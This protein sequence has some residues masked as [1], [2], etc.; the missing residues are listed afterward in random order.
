MV[1]NR[2]K[3][4]RLHYGMDYIYPITPGYVNGDIDIYIN[5]LFL[6]PYCACVIP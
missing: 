1:Q 2:L 3:I 6:L 4:P 5:T